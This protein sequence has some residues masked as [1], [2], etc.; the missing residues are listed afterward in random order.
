MAHVDEEF[1]DD[2][3][4]SVL[5]LSHRHIAELPSSLLHGFDP[6]RFRFVHVEGNDLTSDRCDALALM[7]NL[8]EVRAL[9]KS[10]CR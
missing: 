2:T 1:D 3:E 8:E 7:V 9:V 5:D 6:R 4:G 10:S